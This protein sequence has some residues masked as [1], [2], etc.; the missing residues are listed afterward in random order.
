MASGYHIG[1]WRYRMFPSSQKVLLNSCALE[2]WLHLQVL[3][4]FTSIM[5]MFH[6]IVGWIVFPHNSCWSPNPQYLRMW[7]VKSGHVGCA[8]IQ[9]DRH[10]YKK[11]KFGHKKRHQGCVHREKRPCEGTVRRRLS[12]NQGERP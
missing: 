8:L 2:C 6:P 3:I 5:S 1:E 12:V 10:P 7:Q 4:W 11:K 9:S